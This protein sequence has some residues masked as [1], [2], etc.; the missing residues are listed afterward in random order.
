[1]ITQTEKFKKQICNLIALKNPIQLVW[2]TLQIFVLASLHFFFNFL[3][4]NF[5]M[6]LFLIGE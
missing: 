3:K 6:Y 4:K 5:L 1:M 2:L